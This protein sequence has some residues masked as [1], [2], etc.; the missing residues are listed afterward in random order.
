MVNGGLNTFLRIFFILEYVLQFIAFLCTENNPQYSKSFKWTFF[1][2]YDKELGFTWT[3]HQGIV[4][5]L[6]PLKICQKNFWWREE[7]AWLD[8]MPQIYSICSAP[9]SPPATFI[10][11][12]LVP[13]GKIASQHLGKQKKLE[14]VLLTWTKFEEVI[15]MNCLKSSRPQ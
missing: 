9:P 3:K 1:A 15:L 8:E 11:T 5:H 4:L 12:I 6:F 14:K 13:C 10:K 7:N 2:Y